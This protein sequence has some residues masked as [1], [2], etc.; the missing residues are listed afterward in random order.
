MVS[1]L[2]YGKVS[3]AVLR[4]PTRLDCYDGTLIEDY[5]RGTMVSVGDAAAVSAFN[6]V[7]TTLPDL[8]YMMA[9]ISV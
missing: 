4:S 3:C 7:S 6:V 8:L 2:G 5:R 1:G 9:C